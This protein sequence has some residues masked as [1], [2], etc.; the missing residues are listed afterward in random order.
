MLRV[1]KEVKPKQNIFL[2]ND[3]FLDTYN[4]SHKDTL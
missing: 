2:E 4:S 3:Y 1:Y